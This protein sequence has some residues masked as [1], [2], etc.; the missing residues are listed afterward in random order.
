MSYQAT[1]WKITTLNNLICM[2]HNLIFVS[3]KLGYS[4]HF[5]FIINWSFFLFYRKEGVQAICNINDT[6]ELRY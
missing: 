1:I 5:K 4:L 2:K 6:T 3:I